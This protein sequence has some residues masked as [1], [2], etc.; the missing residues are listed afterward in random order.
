ML[1]VWDGNGVKLGCGDVC[2]TISIIKFI[3]LKKKKKE[4]QLADLVP[5]MT[6]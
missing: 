1:R 2:I 5:I 6:S 4:E 3:K